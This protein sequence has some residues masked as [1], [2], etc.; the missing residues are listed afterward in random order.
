[1]GL[2]GGLTLWSLSV[3]GFALC[4]GLTLGAEVGSPSIALHAFARDGERRPLHDR[5]VGIL[6]PAFSVHTFAPGDESFTWLHR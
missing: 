5:P 6:V 1:M 4:G 2:V 3:C